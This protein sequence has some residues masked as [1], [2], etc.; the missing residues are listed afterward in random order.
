MSARTAQPAAIALIGSAL[1]ALFAFAIV[2][3]F[4][5]RAARREAEVRAGAL[6]A[7]PARFLALSLLAY[8]GLGA[9]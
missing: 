5:G 7:L 6:R 3:V 8:F 9:F 2:A 4:L 1:L